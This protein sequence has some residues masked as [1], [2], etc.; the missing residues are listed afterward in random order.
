MCCQKTCWILFPCALYHLLTS[1]PEPSPCK[2]CLVDITSSLALPNF[3][4]ASLT[5]TILLLGLPSGMCVHSVATVLRVNAGRSSKKTSVQNHPFRLLSS[6]QSILGTTAE[7]TSTARCEDRTTKSRIT[8]LKIPRNQ[9]HDN[10]RP[11]QR[12]LVGFQFAIITF[13]QHS[14]YNPRGQVLG[15]VCFCLFTATL[16]DFPSW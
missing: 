6:V 9:P 11:G 5:A 8:E 2:P 14:R 7:A 3:R 16:L 15:F 4:P 10:V 13:F 1:P 12:K